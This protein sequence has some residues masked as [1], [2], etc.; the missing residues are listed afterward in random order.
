MSPFFNLVNFIMSTFIIFLLNSKELY[1]LK[2]FH[3]VILGHYYFFCYIEKKNRFLKSYNLYL[4][5]FSV[6]IH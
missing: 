6:S 3:F 1:Y 4:K 5:R 2:V